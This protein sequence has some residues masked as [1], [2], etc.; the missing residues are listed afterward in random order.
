[1]VFRG[2][3]GGPKNKNI[4]IDD[5]YKDFVDKDKKVLIIFVLD[6]QKV[7]FEEVN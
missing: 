3:S 1:M 6:I 4:F 2:V 5:L 7:L